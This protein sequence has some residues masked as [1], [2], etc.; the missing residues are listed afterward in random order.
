MGYRSEVRI[1]VDKG[2]FN[3]KGLHLKEGL[4]DCDAITLVE[5]GPKPFYLFTWEHVK[6]YDSY[7][8][9][10]E[11]MEFLSELEEENYGF[12]RVGEEPSDVE[13]KGS[14]YDFDLGVRMSVSA[15]EG[16]DIKEDFFK[17]NTIKFIESVSKKKKTKKVGV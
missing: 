12:I 3:K 11:V 5:S 4:K 1:A 7:P 15:P 13:E 9:V 16:V 2:I 8:E 6:W 17:A 10:S 14:P